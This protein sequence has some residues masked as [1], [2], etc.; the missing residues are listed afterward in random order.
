[1][2]DRPM[3]DSSKN[4]ERGVLEQLPTSEIWVNDWVSF[5]LLPAAI[6]FSVAKGR[7]QWK[8]TFEGK[9]VLESK[10]TFGT[11]KEAKQDAKD[12]LRQRLLDIYD[13][14]PSTQ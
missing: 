6:A 10:V 1:M 8:Y 2:E 9:V 3:A 13:D 7:H 12:Q 5:T 4:C 14:M 11:L